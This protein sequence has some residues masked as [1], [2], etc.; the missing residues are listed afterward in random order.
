MSREK[1]KF[2]FSVREGGGV[3][4]GSEKDCFTIFPTDIS[5]TR[6]AFR[7]GGHSKKYGSF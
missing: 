7:G 6:V 5:Y 1:E 3:I 4:N 2:Y